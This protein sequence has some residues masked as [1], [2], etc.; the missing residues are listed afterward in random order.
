M[1]VEKYKMIYT[2]IIS[3]E[4]KNELPFDVKRL[5]DIEKESENIRIL[6]NDNVKNNKNKGKRIINIK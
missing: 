1:E 3:E 2:K 4:I 5:I 6:D